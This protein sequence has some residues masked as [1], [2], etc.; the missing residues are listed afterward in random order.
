[1]VNFEEKKRDMLQYTIGEIITVLDKTYID[2]IY[3]SYIVE[4]FQFTFC[5]ILRPGI[6]TL[7]KG[8]LFNGKAGLFNPSNTVAYLGLNLPSNRNSEFSRSGN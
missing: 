2:C 5:F 1:V 8:V 6:P 7:W 4:I 3:K